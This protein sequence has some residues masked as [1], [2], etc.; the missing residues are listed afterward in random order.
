MVLGCN[1]TSTV[2]N[3]ISDLQSDELATFDGYSLDRSE[4]EERYTR[5]SGEKKAAA[6]QPMSE[7][8]DFLE[9]YVNFRLKV[10]DAIAKGLDQDPELQK[11]LKD[12][13]DQLAR[14][15]L[16]EQEVIDS[17]VLDV[18]NKQQEQIRASHILIRVEEN[19][20]S[21]TVQ[22][23]LEKAN[24]LVDSLAAG[25]DFSDIALRYS[26][27]PSAKRNQGDLGYFT[28]GRMILAFEEMAYNTPVG[29]SSPPFRTRF[30]YH[31][32][33]VTDRKP[34]EPE[35]RASHILIRTNGPDTTEAYASAQDLLAKVK[36]GEDFDALATQYSEDTGSGKN[37]GDLNFF[38]KDRMVPAFGEA[39]YNLVNIGDVSDVVKT[40][41]GYHIIKLTDR[42]SL[43][44]YD[45]AYDEVK[46]I[47]KRL[48]RAAQREEELGQKF[49]DEN[50]STVDAAQITN[51]VAG[52]LE[53]SLM[54]HLQTNGFGETGAESVIGTIGSSNFTAGQFTEWLKSLRPMP[55]IKTRAQLDK[56]VERFLNVKAIDVASNSLEDR[57]KE[58][59][60]LMNEYRDGI[61][62]F[63]VM[64]DSVW[65]K[66]TAD[67]AGQLAFYNSKKDSYQFPERKRVLSFYS[68]KDSLLKV[69]DASLKA[70]ESI[71]MVYYGEEDSIFKVDTTFVSD[72]TNSIYDRA[73]PLAPGNATEIAAYRRGHILL[74]VDGLEAPRQK[75]FSEARAEVITG[76]QD[77]LEKEWVSKL[78]ARYN[79]KVYPERL[80]GIFPNAN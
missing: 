15:Y 13:R 8:V 61:I 71:D 68:S 9:R 27:D 29:Q 46:K 7:Y 18:Y 51:L 32:L 70:G 56:Q 45:E 28:G 14:P 39:A 48:P 2:Q 22:T 69:I 41:F 30:G 60:E 36:A 12:Y 65:N 38:P 47:V 66:A 59:K 19:A 57:N 52:V 42:K 31:I 80:K 11:E 25:A 37:G 79:A 63:R 44:T 35:I 16:V 21:A 53:D 54:M 74:Y 49:R 10:T 64:E 1:S 34:A 58:F 77:K 20:D 17:L 76:Y 67:T 33:N 40:R 5:T 24:S 23:A 43:P 62:L 26:E 73:L 72:S 75:S 78:R 55:Q 3:P 4:F 6:S 50:G